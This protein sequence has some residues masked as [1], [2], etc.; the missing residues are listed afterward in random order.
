MSGAKLIH[1]DGRPVSRVEVAH[2]RMKG[3]AGSTPYDAADRHSAEMAGWNPWLGAP[4]Q[5]LGPYRDTIV[6][7]QRDLVRNDGWASGAVTNVL[8]SVVGANL[9]PKPKP[10]FRSLSWYSS[11]FDAT[12]AAEFAMQASSLWRDWAED[13]AR[14]CDAARRHTI[15]QII[16]LG[17]RHK[18]VD[19]DAVAVMRYLP[20]RRGYGK[21][22]YATAVKLMDPDRL[23]NPNE[24][25]DTS[26]LKGGI[27]LDEEEAAIAYHFRSAHPGDWTAGAKP[28]VWDR[29]PR[30]SDTGRP[31][32]IHDFDADRVGQTR[33]GAGILAPVLSRLRMLAKYDSAELQAA[34]IN[35]IFAAFI[36]SPNDPALVQ[37]ALGTEDLP[38]YQ[39]MRADFH[40]DKRLRLGD[41]RIATLFPGEKLTFANAAR[42]STAFPQFE[43][44]MLRNAASA[45][46]ASAP[47]IS[48]AWG[49]VNYSSARAA[50]LNAWRTVT[51][52]RADYATGFCTPI[53]S[54]FLEEALDRGLL[55]L[56]AGAPDFV[57]ER[58]AYARC[59]WYGP[60]RGWIDPV[61]EKQGAVLGIQNYL[62]TYEQEVAENGGGD[63]EETMAQRA[64][65]EATRK[66]LGLPDPLGARASKIMKGGEGTKA[67]DEAEDAAAD[68]FG[69][70][71]PIE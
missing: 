29:L 41:A 52:R 69:A 18:L 3:L 20:G 62:S 44:A 39:A 38:A 48:Q 12:W 10:D 5:E 65:E 51:R 66:R 46:G 11:A 64:V 54:C 26:T 2:A 47:E 35:A 49:D 31:I 33:G 19:G 24:A 30:E 55:P 13:P 14:W 8:D 43:A 71:E 28:W 57:E 42:P 22:S 70:E 67:E 27:E 32:V 36:E 59:A 4:D 37:D 50:A 1:P 63:W 23:C 53:Y 6:A 9:R 34:L 25:M 45:I 16:R 60:G 15:P 58:A 40:S 17:F 21:A 56:P 61:K 68:G 7:R